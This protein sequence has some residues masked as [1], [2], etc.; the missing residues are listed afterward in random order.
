MVNR[1]A[2][3]TSL[4]KY[5]LFFVVFGAVLN[6]IINSFGLP[7][8]FTA[9]RTVLLIL[10]FF[11]TQKSLKG[12]NIALF[13]VYFILFVVFYMSVA[14]FQGKIV[15]GLYF[16]R[17]YA[18]P[19]LVLFLARLF[20]DKIDT[21]IIKTIRLLAIASVITSLISLVSFY[22]KL[23]VINYFH[24]NAEINHHWFL[25]GGIIY[26]TGFP[27]GGPNQLGLLFTS[28]IIINAIH[29][30][31]DKRRNIYYNGFLLI[32]LLFTF[33][34][35]AILALVVFLILHSISY[36]SMLKLIPRVLVSLI[37][38][39]V[40]IYLLDQSVFQGSFANY[41]INFA[42]NEDPSTAGHFD[43]L[44]N[45]VHSF[46]EYFLYG[47]E[48]GTVGSR[49]KQFTADYKNVES[50]VFILLFD[51]GL[52][53]VIPYLIA[54]GSLFMSDGIYKKQLCY[55]TAILIPF[56]VLPLIH[57][58]EICAVLFFLSIIAEKKWDLVQNKSNKLVNDFNHLRN[59]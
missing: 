32:G 25:L 2:F 53:V 6:N 56:L 45:A 5:Y 44:V 34:K 10:I 1:T 20:L 18:E 21:S 14:I 42:R 54:V 4:W 48:K 49:A 58:L 50:S 35:S 12:R 17:L 47:Y 15:M 40:I 52:V 28:F 37:F 16:L 31:K 26:R 57:S 11:F 51:M 59:I 38:L 9:L 39:S 55:L 3:I 43:S 46:E 23:P 27:I 36:N 22:L 8:L 13:T 7:N 29:P 19:I 41:L 30:I 24:G 33:S